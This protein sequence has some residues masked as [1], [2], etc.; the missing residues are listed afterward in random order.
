MTR[1]H[2]CLLVLALAPGCG[3][4]GAG[5]GDGGTGDGDGGTGA[6]ARVVDPPPLEDLP[7]A[8]EDAVCE[9]VI[10]CGLMPD[11]QTC[12]ETTVYL[13][14]FETIRAS[15]QA[16]RII[17]HDDQMVECMN[18]FLDA[19][20][21]I[22]S[23][24]AGGNQEACTAAFEGTVADGGACVH[25]EE[26]ISNDCDIV[27]CPDMCC[28]GTCGPTPAHDVAIGQACALNDDCVTGAWCGAGNTCEAQLADGA[29]CTENAACGPPSTCYSDACGP[30]PDEGEACDPAEFL[31]ECDRFDNYCDSGT[32][33]CTRQAHAGEPC[34][35]LGPNPGDDDCVNTAW[36]NGGTCEYLPL[37]GE[38]CVDNDCLAD[39]TC[40]ATNTCVAGVYEPACTI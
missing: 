1:I 30:I 32:M 29:A 2:A 21:S 39:S 11:L 20:C 36:C 35:M 31:F 10:R 15:I 19:D 8:L 16:G 25:E 7:Q 34:T 38:T 37:P 23:L 6:D 13:D 33:I 27:G 24:L 4:D 28:P 17:Y 3:G 40:D 14:D 18:V 26:C 9:L 22:T 12:R 5:D